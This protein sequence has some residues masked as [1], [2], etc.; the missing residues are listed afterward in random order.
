MRPMLHADD[1]DGSEAPPGSGMTTP[2]FTKG[3]TCANVAMGSYANQETV[4]TP[5]GHPAGIDR[6]IL[7]S[8]RE[9]WAA[10]IVTLESCCGH[11][12]VDGY[13]AVPDRHRPAMEAAG[14]QPHPKAPH[15]Y[16]WPKE[17][18]R[19]DPNAAAERT[20]APVAHEVGE[21]TRSLPQ[22]SGKPPGDDPSGSSSEPPLRPT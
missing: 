16:L 22:A 1:S 14:Y 4:T 7:P 10:G 20:S 18:D 12:M 9:L 13:I 3:C 6:C 11:G 21:H 8:V 17:G 19:P 5:V 15:V 2:K